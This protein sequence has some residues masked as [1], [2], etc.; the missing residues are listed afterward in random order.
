MKSI[1]FLLTLGFGLLLFAFTA[2]ESDDDIAAPEKTDIEKAQD[3]L[4]GDIV[5]STRATMNGVDKTLLPTGCPTKFNFSWKSADT[6]V[7]NLVDFHVGAMPFEITFRCACKFMNLNSWEKD[8]YPGAGW[9]KFLGK[10]GNVTSSGD[11]NDNQQ[12]SGATVQG[13]LNV[14]TNETEFLINYNVM[15]VR[16]ETFLQKIDTTRI[17][18]F[19]EEF[20]QYEA[21]LKKWKEEHGLN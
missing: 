14:I 3:I 5:L 12:G 16:T 2:C 8:E 9:V 7:M 17:D 19:D 20:A 11:N 10:D 4:A 13:Y 15:N 18:H 21:D 6:M 1:K